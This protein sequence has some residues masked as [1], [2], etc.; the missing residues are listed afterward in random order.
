MKKFDVLDPNT[1]VFGHHF[2]E[3]SAGTGKTFTIENLIPRLLLESKNPLTIEEILVVTFTR[4]ATRELKSR[5]YANLLKI[6]RFLK[7]KKGG[8]L[9]L[10][11]F[12]GSNSEEYYSAK[13][14][15]EEAICNFE[16]AQ[17]FTLHGF[18][19]RSLQ[20]FAF[21]ARFGVGVKEEDMMS[22]R[23]N[24]RLSAVKDF[25]IGSLS[26]EHF[27]LAQTEIVLKDMAREGQ[28][29]SLCQKI[30]AVLQKADPIRS[31]LGAKE[32]WEKVDALFAIGDPIKT[33]ELWN[34]FACAF[35]RKAKSEKGRA[36]ILQLFGWLENKT[37]PYSEWDSWLFEKK[38]LL[39][40]LNLEISCK[41]GHPSHAACLERLK[42][43]QKDFIP[44][45]EE[46]RNPKVIL[47]RMAQAC[48]PFFDKA[49]IDTM[50]IDP[51]DL[52]REMQGAL[53]SSAF[54][55]KIRS[56]YRVAMI[57][58][59]QDT[60]PTQ[61]EIFR[62]LFLASQEKKTVYF[63]GDPKQSIYAFRSADVYTYLEAAQAVGKE[64]LFCLDTNYRSHPRL[65]EA[66][67]TLFTENIAPEWMQLP[68]QKQSLTV[69]KVGSKEDGSSLLEE[70]AIGRVHF[71]LATDERGLEKKWPRQTVEEKKLFPFFVKEIQR[72]QKE[73]GLAYRQMAVLVKDRF[74]AERLQAFL[75]EYEIPCFMQKSLDLAN[76]LA[77]S[78]MEEFFEA[79]SSPSNLSSLKKVLGGAMVGFPSEKIMGS[80]ENPLLLEAREYF[81]CAAKSLQKKGFG[82]IFQDFLLFKWTGSKETVLEKLVAANSSLYFEV[83]Q[84]C[85]ALLDHRPEFSHDLF[86]LSAFLSSLKEEP[87]NSEFLQQIAEQEEDQVV[88]M[89]IHKSKGL[90]FDVV[91]ALGLCYR[92]T[93]EE[94]FIQIRQ[95]LQREITIPSQEEAYLLMRKELDA[96][97]LRQL[98]VALTRAK[99]RVYIPLVLDKN[100]EGLQE[101]CAAPIELFCLGFQADSY[102]FDDAYRRYSQMTLSFIKSHLES[103]QK[104]CS[105]S[106][107]I[108]EED[109]VQEKEEPLFE[110]LIFS[111]FSLPSFPEKKLLSF[112]SLAKEMESESLDVLVLPSG[113]TPHSFPL[114]TET[115]TIV[116]SILEHL[117]K[118]DLHRTYDLRAF[119]WI[120]HFCKGTSLDG[121]EDVLYPWIGELFEKPLAEAGFALKEIP[122][123]SMHTELEFVFPYQDTMLKGFIDLFFEFQGKYYVLDWKTNFLGDSDACY[124]F[125]NIE[126]AIKHHHYDLQAA[127]Y[128]QAMRS[129]LQLFD[130]KKG[131]SKFAG[132]IYYFV[133]GKAPYIL[134]PQS[135]EAFL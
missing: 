11:P 21:E 79:L 108:L 135:M 115:G 65:I 48:R 100:P 31:F 125:L 29:D 46:A 77:Y 93:T 89:T 72:L 10:Q 13:R 59:F 128:A 24:A 113:R 86:H 105:L 99:E 12:Q 47:L 104:I 87:S 66:L 1:G 7:E 112:S 110:P 61:W 127:I 116:H 103:L 84:I 118:A 88:V 5:I 124:N 109:C 69:R 17:I 9:Y 28:I 55:E 50:C 40:E 41:C 38:M 3:A 85:Q 14:K 90:E 83:R 75:R 35:P 43:L 92:H 32:C 22:P 37:C 18:C 36:Q 67:N 134:Y 26:Q 74:Q 8:P 120:E 42:Q 2:L 76:S 123:S 91:F 130:P 27:S 73:K 15:I 19:L 71:L 45:W 97:K 56:K 107:A 106:F 64:N 78:S 16:R 20:E 52:V 81:S 39:A 23:Q 101:G 58:E 132:A 126:S 82:A 44:L 94:A 111:S 70:D 96:E 25:L 122:S 117:C 54:C 133:R 4:A 6:E 102:S 131:F 51:D 95:G 33:E 30:L 119:D 80:W 60:D 114:G 129:Y 34:A 98:Y 68:S 49:R 57:D 63:V 53:Q 121:W 62:K